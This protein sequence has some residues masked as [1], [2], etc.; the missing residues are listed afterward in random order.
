M[1][2]IIFCLSLENILLGVSLVVLMARVGPWLNALLDLPYFLG[3]GEWIHQKKKKK[4][5]CQVKS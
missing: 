3:V 1:V 4:K 2:H 5:D